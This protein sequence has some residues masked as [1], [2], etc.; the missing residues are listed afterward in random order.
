M[1]S[2]CVEFYKVSFIETEQ[3]SDYRRL[4]WLRRGIQEILIKEYKVSS[5]LGK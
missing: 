5:N 4:E 3:K 1:I 2:L